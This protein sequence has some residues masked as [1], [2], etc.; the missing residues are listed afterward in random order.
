MKLRLHHV[1]LVTVGATLLLSN[2]VILFVCFQQRSADI[3]KAYHD[4]FHLTSKA[5]AYRSF[6]VIQGGTERQLPYFLSGLLTDQIHYCVITDTNKKVLV[7]SFD[8]EKQ[9]SDQPLS[10]WSKGKIETIQNVILGNKD[11]SYGIQ[12]MVGRLRSF[13]PGTLTTQLESM[14]HNERI[15]EVKVA[16]GD[17]GK[18]DVLDSRAA[19]MYI[20][21]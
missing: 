14:I 13:G 6:F 17:T 19:F 10:T 15:Y 1:L 4:H 21:F 11:Q 12:K 2:A 7:S 8:S 16:F 3:Q 9:L 5:F 20:G 18:L